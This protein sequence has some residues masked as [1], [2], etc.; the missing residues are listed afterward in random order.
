MD[1]GVFLPVANN[2]WLVSETAP[3]YL[4][5]Y[6]LNREIVQLAE[7]H[8]LDF[9]LSMVKYRGYGGPT[10]YWDHSLESFALNAALAAV[11]D[12]I[13]LYASAPILAIPP[14]VTARLATTIDSVAPGRFGINIVTGWQ[15]AEYEQMGLWPG[16]DHYRRRYDHAGEYVSILR[17]L[18]ERG[19]SSFRGD[20]YSYDDCR[21]LPRP[22]AAVPVVGAGQSER[23]IRFCAEH[24]DFNFIA[25]TGRNDPMSPAGQVA[26]LRSAAERSGR[27]VGAYALVMVIAAETDDEAWARWRHYEEGVD[28][29]ALTW[30][31]S[32]SSLD[33]IHK[34]ANGS[35]VD[36]MNRAAATKAVNQGLGALIGSYENVA[37]M[38]DQLAAVEGISGIMLVFDDFIRGLGDFGERIQPL[39]DCRKDRVPATPD[40]GQR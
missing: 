39:L 38:L 17:E 37:G 9:A 20:F 11:T 36:L 3:Q 6:E 12:R 16:D 31:T 14:A 29:E 15:A 24:C 21:L 26:A 28:V 10:K 30:L 18:F 19:V 27:D 2:G 40:T 25:S 32:Q 33:Q 1:L 34:V 7:R 22:S 35:S 4:P 23:G 5:T 8:R 13:R